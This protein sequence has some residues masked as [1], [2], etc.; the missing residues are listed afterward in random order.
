M[1]NVSRRLGKEHFNVETRAMFLRTLFHD[2]FGDNDLSTL[3]NLKTNPM[4]G[5][6][7]IDEP[8]EGS[9]AYHIERDLAAKEGAKRR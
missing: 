2:M 4:A 6:I 7:I 3:K 8:D 1:W 9:L 5:N